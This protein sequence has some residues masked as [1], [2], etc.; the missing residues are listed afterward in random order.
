MKL[1][2][3]LKESM[4]AK[5]I[6][7]ADLTRLTGA[8]RS[9]ISLWLNDGVTSISGENLLKVA[10]ILS[11]SPKW[12]NDG[13]GKPEMTMKGA[14]Y[15]DQ[16]SPRGLH[17]MGQLLDIEQ[18]QKASNHLYRLI[19]NALVLA[20]A[21]TETQVARE[22]EHDIAALSEQLP[23]HQRNALAVFLKSLAE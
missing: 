4:A 16:L 23:A 14:L 11:V 8:S 13:I 17:L 15:E 20:G 1:S 6:N 7:Q 10:K 18:K 3:R 19:E 5:G 12:L 9:T 2:E 22:G 21:Q